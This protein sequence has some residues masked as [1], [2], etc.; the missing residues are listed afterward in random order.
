MGQDSKLSGRRDFLKGAAT[1]AAVGALGASTL[2]KSCSRGRTTAVM[3]EFLDQAPDGRVLKAGII[4]C[5]YRAIGAAINFLNAGNGLEVTALGDVFENR[6][7]HCRQELNERFDVE[8]ADENCFIGFDA[9]E[10]V[11]DSDVDIVILATPPFFR[12]LHFEA[13]VRARKH[14]FMEKPVAVDPVGARSIMASA[15]M[16]D[17]A[18]LKVVTGTQRRHQRDYLSTYAHI[19]NGI[20]GDIVGANCYWNQSRLWHVN[21]Q[22]GWD[23]MTAMLRDWVNWCWLSGDHIVEQHMHNIDVINWFTGKHPVKAVGFGARHRRITGDQYDFFSVDYIYDDKTHMHSMCR[24]IDE[25]SNNVS[26]Y[27]VGTEGASNCQ[28]TIIN[29]KGETIWSFEYPLDEEGQPSRREMKSPYD[30]EIINLV[31]A[32]RSNKPLNEAEACA[33]STMVAIMGRISAYTGQEVTWEQM[34]NSGMRLGPSEP[35]FGPVNIRAEI[36]VPGSA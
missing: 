4:G 6:L 18:G 5:G 30:Q 9:Y 33:V 16:A 20:I 21:R 22:Q 25:C 11:I 10:K 3:P 13:A 32:I 29:H 2:F 15:R 19:K 34:M 28:N 23:D 24:Q 36:P 1:V 7:N 31:D 8:I 12:P 14:V 26:E 17:A 27:I 35:A